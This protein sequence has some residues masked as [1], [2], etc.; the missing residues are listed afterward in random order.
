M[1]DATSY[2]VFRPVRMVVNDHDP[3]MPRVYGV[4]SDGLPVATSDWFVDDDGCIVA[5]TKEKAQAAY[6]L[7]VWLLECRLGWRICSR[8]T[9]GPTRCL[10]FT[11]L[12]IDTV[13][14]DVGGPCVRLGAE[15]RARARARVAEFMRANVWRMRAHRRDLASLIGELSYAANAVPAGR[16]FLVRLY[17]A[18]HEM[19]AA[20]SGDPTN[21]DREVAL[22]AASV[23]DLKWWLDCLDVAPC[24]RRWRSRTFA[25]HRCWSDASNYGFAESLAVEPHAGLPAMAFTHGVWPDALAGFSSNWHELATVVYSIRQRARDLEGSQIHY[26]TD[27]TTTVKAV[28]TGTVSSPSLMKLVRELK[29]VQ[30][31]HDIGVEAFHLPGRIMIKQGTDG[32]SRQTPWLG[33]YGGEGGAHDAFSPI[34]WPR[35]ELNGSIV[36]VLAGLVGPDTLDF[37]DPTS[38]HQQPDPAGRD[39]F[40]H[41]RPAHA[42]AGFP[43]LMDAQLRM[44]RSTSF[45]VVV[46]Q[47]GT[48]R[49][50]RFL[51]HFRRKEVHDVVVPALGVVRHWVLRFEPGDAM[52]PR[53]QRRGQAPLDAFDVV[54]EQKRMSCSFV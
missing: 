54:E 33:M 48:S 16:A 45:T 47:V 11:G 39:V 15:R 9:V 30:A 2:D 51:K 52:L 12:E 27:N 32:A 18:L 43:L 4:G 6:D 46:A 3:S 5:P 40:T 14:S 24:V 26:M 19:R 29:H 37:S 31:A 38:W 36:E 20:K 1:R 7:L 8:K 17:D 44:G 35:F 50:S 21:Y 22:T 23:L 25:L 34:E 49:W 13:G 28:N 41:W 42:G 10:A 53:A